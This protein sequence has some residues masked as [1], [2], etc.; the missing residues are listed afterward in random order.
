VTH[1]IK[2]KIEEGV[3]SPQTKSVRL[4][5]LQPMTTYSPSCKS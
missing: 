3:V 4:S 1:N 5:F 2:L